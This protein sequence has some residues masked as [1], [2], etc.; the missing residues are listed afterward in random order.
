MA[1]ADDCRRPR[2]TPVSSRP[3]FVIVT[4]VVEPQMGDATARRTYS[5]LM[6]GRHYDA[7]RMIEVEQ[8]PNELSVVRAPA[9]F[10]PARELRER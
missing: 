5:A 7:W 6:D 10:L 2:V 1:F 9:A 8:A 4:R 3:G